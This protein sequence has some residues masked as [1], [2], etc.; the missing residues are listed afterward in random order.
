[1][2]Y[3]TAAADD[4]FRTFRST[5][6]CQSRYL[7]TMG[8]QNLGETNW[9]RVMARWTEQSRGRNVSKGFFWT[10]YN[11]IGI[12]RTQPFCMEMIFTAYLRT[13][14]TGCLVH[15]RPNCT[16]TTSKRCAQADFFFGCKQVAAGCMVA[17]ISFLQFEHRGKVQAN[18]QSRSGYCDEE[19]LV[20]VWNFETWYNITCLSG[21]L[22]TWARSTGLVRPSGFSEEIYFS[23]A[24]HSIRPLEHH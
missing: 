5:L 18:S 21:W 8:E 4:C 2:P 24:E 17:R 3:V 9:F 15:C 13:W 6:L 7:G 23:G 22:P 11:P 10:P 1:M 14:P 16:C 19:Y 12:D 20:R